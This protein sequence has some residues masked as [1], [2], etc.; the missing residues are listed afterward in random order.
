MVLSTQV[1]MH[2]PDKLD[3]LQAGVSYHYFLRDIFEDLLEKLVELSHQEN[4]LASQPCRDNT[5][6]FMRLIDEFLL[7][8]IDHKLPVSNLSES[9][10]KVVSSSILLLPRTTFNL[11]RGTGIRN[12]A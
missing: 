9:S 1:V 10:N 3:I 6:Y 8:E 4:I 12:A 2:E 11:E 7:S 5:L